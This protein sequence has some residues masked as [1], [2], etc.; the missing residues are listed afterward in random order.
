M[1]EV[2][3]IARLDFVVQNSKLKVFETQLQRRKLIISTLIDT[4]NNYREKFPM[5]K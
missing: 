2:P 5:Q 3:V 4:D 1:S